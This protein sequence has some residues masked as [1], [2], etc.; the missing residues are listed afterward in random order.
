L[1]IALTL[2]VVSG[3]AA[4]AQE[5]SDPGLPFVAS[6]TSTLRYFDLRATEGWEF[7]LDLEERLVEALFIEV[8]VLYEL[9][10]FA[11][12]AP[13]ELSQI[14]L[15][16]TPFPEIDRAQML[17]LGGTSHLPADEGI[18]GAEMGD[19]PLALDALGYAGMIDEMLAVI[20]AVPDEP[21]LPTLALMAGGTVSVVAITGF[22]IFGRRRRRRERRTPPELSEVHHRLI[23]ALD[24]AQIA[25]I[26]VPEAMRLTDADSG[27]V[28]R[29]IGIGGLRLT[30]SSDPIEGSRFRSAVDT[31]QPV[32]GRLV[33]DPLLPG[34]TVHVAAVPLIAAGT[35]SG[36]I[37]VWR[38]SDRPFDLTARDALETL[39]PY[40]AVA[41][42]SADRHGSMTHMALVD[43]LTSLGNRRRLDHDLSATLQKAV[44]AGLPVAFAMVDVDHFKT[45]N[46]TH[47]HGAGDEALKQV[48]GV[49][50]AH[51]R[52]SDIVY[53]YGGEEFSILLPGS[54]TEE[55]QAVAE[56]VRLA[57]QEASFPGEEMQPG[58]TLTVSVGV[59]TLASSA[60]DALKARADAALYEAKSNGRNQ[61]VIA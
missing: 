39:A 6:E 53:R 10:A 20:G 57:V 4:L 46:D 18:L 2:M 21:G 34:K 43:G 50:A 41:L 60:P 9:D 61:V 33:D 22:T 17:D 19:L 7:S 3:P 36:V 11:D 47:G 40:A 42:T 24:E 58:G 52:D 51:V 23:G 38:H 35:T 59:A 15:A 44:A 25:E 45:Y 55:A 31:G 13:D 48:A 8:A 29:P 14:H 1:S 27:A 26:V 37:A 5:S 56:R 16:Y 30:E 28:L 49:I 54:N 32:I 12:P